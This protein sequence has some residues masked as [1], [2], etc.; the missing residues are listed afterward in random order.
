MDLF[1]L[2]YAYLP[3]RRL[4]IKEGNCLKLALPE[5][6]SFFVLILSISEGSSL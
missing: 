5:K 1:E 6:D 2:K 4:K 3:T